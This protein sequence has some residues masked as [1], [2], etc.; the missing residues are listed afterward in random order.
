MTDFPRLIE[1]AF[2]LGPVVYAPSPAYT[3]AG[4]KSEFLS[5]AFPCGP[6][7]IGLVVTG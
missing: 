2:D 3:H 6:D 4:G 1:Y 7:D 5:V